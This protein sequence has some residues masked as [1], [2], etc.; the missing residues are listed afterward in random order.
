MK[1]NLRRL[2]LISKI[3][4]INLFYSVNINVSSIELQGK[5][6]PD[7]VLLCEKLKFNSSYTPHGYVLFHRN[8]IQI[9]L[10]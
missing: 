8:L 7:I 9:T 3:F 4:N 6:N 5:F 2:S 1:T 10:T